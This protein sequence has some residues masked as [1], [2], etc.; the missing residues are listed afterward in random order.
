MSQCL[1]SEQNLNAAKKRSQGLSL[2][3]T[4]TESTQKLDNDILHVETENKQ[5][6][7]HAGK[8]LLVK[9][10]LFKTFDRE[11]LCD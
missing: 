6:F 8:L 9:S 7:T 2:K 3:T 5:G 10:Q 4:P 1:K 11:E